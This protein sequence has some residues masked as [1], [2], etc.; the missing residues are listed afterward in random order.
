M[1]PLAFPGS[2]ESGTERHFSRT[3]MRK[4][5]R[6][7]ALAVTLPFLGACFSPQP[8][9]LPS[10]AQREDVEIQGVVIGDPGDEGEAVRF[11]EIYEVDWGQS[12]LSIQGR[13]GGGGPVPNVVTRRYPYRDLSG[14]LTRQLDVNR[15]SLLIAGTAFVTIS[16]V[17]FLFTERTGGAGPVVVGPGG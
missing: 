7:L 6:A 16:A 9:P 17:V 10:P 14:V 1:Y 15:T 11:D 2:G 4:P 13:L 3:P 12:E 5:P 8:A